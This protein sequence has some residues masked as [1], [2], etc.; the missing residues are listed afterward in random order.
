MPVSVS[1]DYI[2]KMLADSFQN[3]TVIP[4]CLLYNDIQYNIVNEEKMA[5]YS[6]I[7]VITCHSLAWD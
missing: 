6:Y 1:F 3:D 7:A 2:A 4:S 5:E